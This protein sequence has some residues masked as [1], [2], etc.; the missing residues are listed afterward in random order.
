MTDTRPLEGIKVIETGTI[1]AGCYC[2]QLLAD[3]GADVIKIEAPAGRAPDPLRRWGHI[4]PHGES[5]LPSILNRGK[6][7][8]TLDM[9]QTSG[10]EV[11]K[12]LIGNADVLVENFRPGTFERWGLGEDVLRELNPGLIKVSISGYGQTGPMAK[13]PALGAISEAMAGLRGLI[14]Y[15][16]RPPVRAG[17]SIGDFLAGLFGALGAVMSLYGRQ[18][19]GLGEVVDVAIYEAVMSVIEDLLPVYDN[20][21]V[22][23][24][25]V[26][27]GMGGPRG[28]APSDVYLSADDEW[29]LIAA[30]SDSLFSRLVAVMERPELLEDE[31][32]RSHAN[33]AIH[34][35]EINDY[36]AAWVGA[37][38]AEDVIAVLREADVPSAEVAHASD[39][40]ANPHINARE[41]IIELEDA[42]FGHVKMQGVVPKLRHR[43]GRVDRPGLELG[44]DTE[45]ILTT[46]LLLEPA[47]VEEL[48]RDGV[49]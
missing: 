49:I 14:G 1:I 12:R 21:G 32:F 30:P 27:T 38:R 6:R 40:L 2:G 29:V 17:V 31:R 4:G 3:F 7:L 36:V 41:M 45:S 20:L 25:P 8:M 23:K 48:T 42:R 18:S 19:D 24:G 16:D 47:D 15:E 35:Q 44:R 39:I 37:R 5:F 43:P 33:R 10:A 11:F 46:D 22:K 9:S 13:L 28:A 34:K 26:G